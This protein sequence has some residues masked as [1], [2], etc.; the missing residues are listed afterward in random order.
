[1]RSQ[2]TEYRRAV[3]NLYIRLRRLRD[4]TAALANAYGFD[5]PRTQSAQQAMIEVHNGL[6]CMQDAALSESKSIIGSD[7]VHGI[8]LLVEAR[9]RRAVK[10]LSAD[11]ASRFIRTVGKAAENSYGDH[12]NLN[13]TDGYLSDDKAESLE[14]FLETGEVTGPEHVARIIE[15]VMEYG[16]NKF[17]KGEFGR[18]FTI[19]N[20]SGEMHPGNVGFV[21]QISK[22]LA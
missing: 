16:R 2:P 21:R 11:E 6:H 7:F 19:D 12:W 14:A 10:G 5:N 8:K 1:M 22:A 20:L 3:A 18:A 17:G 13:A 9:R 4:E 15:S